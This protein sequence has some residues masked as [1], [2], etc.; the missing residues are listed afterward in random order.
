MNIYARLLDGNKSHQLI[1]TLLKPVPV[2]RTGFSFDGGLYPNL[3]DA[4][5]PFQ[6]DGNFGYTAGVVEMLLQSH[7]GE[8]HLLPALPDAWQDG[9]VNGLVARG[10]VQVALSWKNGQLRNT[11]LKAAAN[12]TCKIRYG[13]LTK[14]IS[15]VAQKEYILNEALNKIN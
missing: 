10:N 1:R 15:L 14:E 2:E 13:Q 12:T 8:I 4:H 6:I 7:L 3:F 5:T 11:K 9:S